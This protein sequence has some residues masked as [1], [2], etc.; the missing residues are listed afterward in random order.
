M[1]INHIPLEHQRIIHLCVSVC[2]R[3]HLCSIIQKYSAWRPNPVEERR[4]PM[5]TDEH[6]LEAPYH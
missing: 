2:I 1:R 6:R 4:T 3:V 5:N